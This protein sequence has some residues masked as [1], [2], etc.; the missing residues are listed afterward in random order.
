[1][2]PLSAD[3]FAAFADRI[4]QLLGAGKGEP[5]FV[6]IMTNGTSGD[7]NN[8]NFAGPAPKNQGE[9]EQIRVVADSVAR[10]A[11]AAYQKVEHR[12]WVPLV[13]AQK[14]IELGVRRPTEAEVEKARAI[15]AEAKGKVLTKLPEVYAHETV[16]M[17]K[18]PPRVK[19]LLQ[20]I[21]V[22]DLGIVADPCETFVEIGLEIKK[23]SPLRP[24]FTVE[25][26]NG[27]NGYLPT[28]EQHALGG[29]ETWRARSSYLEVNASRRITDT[30]L[31]LLR[32]VAR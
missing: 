13:M 29:Y 30:L 3:Y 15:L 8:L 4:G 5:P 32:Q 20:A 1:V 19:V 7:I 12:N 16:A 2:Q 25:L 23:K 18:Y 24:T 31:E 11:F 22:G 26:A 21:R 17:A 27:Y 9:Y 10:A 28:Q 14:E 6:G